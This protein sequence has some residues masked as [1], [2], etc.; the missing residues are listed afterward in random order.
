[1]PPEMILLVLGELTLE[2]LVRLRPVCVALLVLVDAIAQRMY[3]A[4]Y[5]TLIDPSHLGTAWAPL[6]REAEK[7][8][9]RRPRDWAED[10]VWIVARGMEK[11]WARKQIPPRGPSQ[12]WPAT[13][14]EAALI[15]AAK[16]V[17]AAPLLRKLLSLLTAQRFSI[18]WAYLVAG[19][20]LGGNVELAHRLATEHPAEVSPESSI[21]RLV[22]GPA[23]C[24]SY[25]M[26]LP[27]S[28]PLRVSV[29]AMLCRC[30]NN[31]VRLLRALQWLLSW[32]SSTPPA[33]P[34]APDSALLHDGRLASPNTVSDSASPITSPVASPLPSAASPYRTASSPASFGI[35]ARGPLLA[36]GAAD[37]HR[38]LPDLRYRDITYTDR[39]LLDLA[40]R[41]NASRS[42]VF[43]LAQASKV[44]SVQ[45]ALREFPTER[46]AEL[47]WLLT[48]PTYEWKTLLREAARTVNTA[49]LSMLLQHSP[50]R[51]GRTKLLRAALESANRPVAEL[52]MPLAKPADRSLLGA[53]IHGEL[54][55]LAVELLKRGAKQTELYMGRP[56]VLHLASKP[57]LPPE[58]R[59]LLDLLLSPQQ[60]ATKAWLAIILNV[61]HEGELPL[62]AAASGGAF[63]LYKVTRLLQAGAKADHSDGDGNTPLLLALK[64]KPHPEQAAVVDLLLQHGASVNA[65]NAADESP[66]SIALA[67]AD[68]ALLSRLINAG[69][70]PHVTPKGCTVLHTWL[71]ERDAEWQQTRTII[72]TLVPRFIHVEARTHDT[73]E[74]LLYYA[75][76]YRRRHAIEVLLMLGASP[77][78]R[79]QSN[80]TPLQLAQRKK[81]AP[82]LQALLKEHSQQSSRCI[83]S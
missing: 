37:H 20:L 2:Q 17:L 55:E 30:A 15:E 63:A 83:I 56:L 52:L 1:M 71:S 11:R 42:V 49:L 10:A 28:V 40:F 65:R 67:R 79:N 68:T 57:F 51:H 48:P 47:L 59:E 62:C 14:A 21:S 34:P 82:N 8:R 45:E 16:N 80:L 74:T 46:T 25:P 39:P 66:L 41:H 54:Y 77:D 18:R 31:D 60:N 33:V 3:E 9:K 5:G 36:A 61:P 29:F 70:L 24:G 13:H 53:A 78:A 43:L 81:L 64:S 22:I 69:A 76:K 75:V 35:S 50:V 23:F 6:L 19:A 72:E 12:P 7:R 73:G 32:T 26:F 38:V 27:D 44:L 58:A 4:K